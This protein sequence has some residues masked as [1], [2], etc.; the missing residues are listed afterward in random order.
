MQRNILKLI[1][2]IFGVTLPVLL[3]DQFT[4]WLIQQN[5]PHHG[6]HVIIQGIL[7][8][9]H[10][11]NDGAAF[12]LMPGQSVLLVIISI[13]AIG[14]IA[15]YYRQFHESLWMKIALSFLLGGALGNFIDR[16]RLR[17]GHRFYSISATRFLV[18]HFQRCRCR[19]LYWC[20]DVNDLPIS[21][22]RRL[23]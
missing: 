9:R 17:G 6:Q 12:G 10:D 13:V 23:R 4:K 22:S 8:L 1:L 5:I 14:F 15:Y 21:A 3:V 16:V 11:T 2:P 18:A 7:N 19:C 20:R